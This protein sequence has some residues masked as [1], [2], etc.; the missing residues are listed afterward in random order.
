MDLMRLGLERARTCRE[1]IEVMAD[2]L[3]AYGQGG[4]C[5]LSGNSHFDSSYILSGTAEAWVLETAGREWAA[6]Q[7]AAFGSISNAYV[8]GDDWDLCSADGNGGMLDWAAA[9]A[10]LARVPQMGAR[11]R[12][13]A[14]HCGLEA[15]AGAITVRSMFNLLRRH[16]PSFHP[17]RGE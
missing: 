9:V 15:E 12:Q 8:I 5:E 11:E 17:A 3:R 16:G 10:D 4:N 7:V 2:L 13:A 6:K 1:A 14:T